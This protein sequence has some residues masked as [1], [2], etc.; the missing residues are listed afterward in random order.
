MAAGHDLEQALAKHGGDANS[1][2]ARPDV[3]DLADTFRSALVACGEGESEL[4]KK[5]APLADKVL[6]DLGLRHLM[7]LLVP[8]ERLSGR[9]RRDEEFLF[10]ESDA[11]GPLA[12][13]LDRIP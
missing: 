13:R 3:D 2:I 5:L 10:S 6:I 9:S 8:I 4:L 7:A 12:K 11:A 1:E